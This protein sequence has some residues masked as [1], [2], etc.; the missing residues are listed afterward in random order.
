M[1]GKTSLSSTLTQA[2]SMMGPHPTLQLKPTRIIDSC[3]V[4]GPITL[5]TRVMNIRM[6][7][8]L[9]QSESAITVSMTYRQT[10]YRFCFRVW[11]P[12]W[13]L[14]LHLFS[15]D[16]LLIFQKM[17]IYVYFSEGAML[18][19]WHLSAKLDLWDNL[20]TVTLKQAYSIIGQ[21]YLVI[22][23]D[24]PYS[25]LLSFLNKVFLPEYQAIAMSW[26]PRHC[27]QSISN[28][29]DHYCIT[30]CL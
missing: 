12:C 2:E 1:E 16:T 13:V 17:Q 3:K 4:K 28:H 5:R 7:A 22:S 27:I 18:K 10:A 23:W 6:W 25:H 8:K 14:M 11:W 9:R 19:M 29:W 15:R 21:C 20:D 26:W 30:S 24:H